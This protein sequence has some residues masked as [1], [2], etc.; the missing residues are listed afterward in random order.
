MTTVLMLSAAPLA[1]GAVDVGGAGMAD[2]ALATP[3]VAPAA[4]GSAAAGQG[5]SPAV[6]PVVFAQLPD[7]ADAGAPPPDATTPA[8]DAPPAGAGS[9]QPDNVIVVQARSAPPP[10]DPMQAVNAQSYAVTQDVDKAFV[11]PAANVYKSVLPRPVRKGL[12][13]FLLNLDQPVVIIS[14]LLE[15]KPG[16]A[17]ES[18]ARFAV[19]STVGIAGVMDVAKNHPFNL[20]YRP[21]DI[22]DV[23]GFYGVGPGPFLFVPLIGPTNLRDLVGLSID[24][25]VVPT[26]FGTPFSKPYYTLPVG[27]VRSLDYRVNFDAEL[28][29]QQDTPDP[30]A[31]SRQYYQEMRKVEIEALH[32]R[33]YKPVLSPE[34]AR[35]GASAEPAP[36]AG[37]APV[38]APVTLNLP[39]TPAAPAAPPVPAPNPAPGAMP[40]TVPVVPPR[41]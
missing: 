2:P 17:V 22:A 41:R 35:H 25:L 30:Y 32:G 40:A 23:M 31:S 7:F 27:V 16:K 8:A 39:A 21:N 5:T 33:V 14:Y 3:P 4:A 36:A 13:N 19:N 24:R 18:L 29:R 34:K 6:P 10:G 20:P 1:P 38:V 15:L 12:H 26:F 28:Q 37:V 11:A 9:G